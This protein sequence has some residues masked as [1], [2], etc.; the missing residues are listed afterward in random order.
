M[1]FLSDLGR[2]GKGTLADKTPTQ[3]QP[4]ANMAIP[5][6]ALQRDITWWHQAGGQIYKFKSER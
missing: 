6:D 4:M 1:T 3:F 2:P 5:G